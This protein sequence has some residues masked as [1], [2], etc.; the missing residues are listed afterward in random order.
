MR[1]QSGEQEDKLLKKREVASVLGV[2]PRSVER[3]ASSGL[4]ARI[5]VLGAIRFRSS[6]VQAIVKG[7]AS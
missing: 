6:E 4:L 2:S 5:R 7:G 1:Q 3:M